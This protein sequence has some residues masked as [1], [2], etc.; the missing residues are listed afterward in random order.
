SRQSLDMTSEFDMCDDSMYNCL[1]CK[2]VAEDWPVFHLQVDVLLCIVI[3]AMILSDKNLRQNYMFNFCLVIGLKLVEVLGGI[4]F[5]SDRYTFCYRHPPRIV[6][7]SVKVKMLVDACMQPLITLFLLF[8]LRRIVRTDLRK[9]HLICCSLGS[10]VL[11]IYPLYHDLK[12]SRLVRFIDFRAEARTMLNGWINIGICCFTL[13]IKNVREDTNHRAFAP[14][15][16]IFI[17][18]FVPLDS[19][20]SLLFCALSFGFIKYAEFGA[21]SALKALAE[22]NNF[23]FWLSAV[24]SIIYLHMAKR[25]YYCQ[26]PIV[27]KKEDNLIEL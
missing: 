22:V 27:Y 21:D 20:I 7:I 15:A 5:A 25:R 6:M 24:I 10:I 23:A 18:T 2:Y 16:L 3:L 12:Q 11:A 13:F 26:R 14:L 8:D 1:M 9:L 19:L 17:I 4:G